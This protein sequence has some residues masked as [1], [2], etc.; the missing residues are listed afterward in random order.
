M[1]A[2]DCI[3]RNDPRYVQIA[4]FEPAC[5]RGPRRRKR[6]KTHSGIGLEQ[7]EQILVRLDFMRG[8]GRI[9]LGGKTSREFLARLPI[10][11]TEHRFGGELRQRDIGL[12]SPG[13][14]V[15]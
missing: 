11:P 1:P 2:G 5:G 3:N 4:K 7:C 13:E 10:D 14:R 15:I 12:V 6:D 9:P 8:P